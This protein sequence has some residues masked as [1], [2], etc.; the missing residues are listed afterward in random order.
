LISA[1]LDAFTQ[2]GSTVLGGDGTF[3]TIERGPIKILFSHGTYVFFVA[4]NTTPIPGLDL[5]LDHLIKKF[6]STYCSHLEN[7]DGRIKRFQEFRFEILDS[8]IPWNYEDTVILSV[9]SKTPTSFFNE[10]LGVT[11]GIK[12]EILQVYNALDGKR[13]VLDIQSKTELPITTVKP[14]LSLL[15][16]THVISVFDMA[17]TSP[18]DLGNQSSLGDLKDNIEQRMEKLGIKHSQLYGLIEVPFFEG[19]LE[20]LPQDQKEFLMFCDGQRSLG[21]ISLLLDK[22]FFDILKLASQSKSKGM[23]YVK[24]LIPKPK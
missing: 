23:K 9:P 8:F 22:P 7:W 19:S 21:I 24:R 10:Y 17:S 11:E 15:E 6:E 1:F 13:N 2:A 20:G 18:E 5:K 14:I 3:S 4:I 12:N 16:Y